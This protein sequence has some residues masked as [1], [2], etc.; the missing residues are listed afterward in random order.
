MTTSAAVAC[1]AFSLDLEQRGPSNGL[2]IAVAVTSAV[3]VVIASALQ[4]WIN[5]QSYG[6]GDADPG[7]WIASALVHFWPYAISVLL[8]PNKLTRREAESTLSDSRRGS[9]VRS[10]PMPSLPHRSPTTRVNDPDAS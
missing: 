10:V 9:Y 8:A 5:H 7:D 6:A 3:L 4:I 2:G 1:G